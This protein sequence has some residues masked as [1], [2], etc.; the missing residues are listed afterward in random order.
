[1]ADTAVKGP[2]AFTASNGTTLE[3][4]DSDFS[5]INGSTGYTGITGNK[6]TF[7]FS[8]NST[9]FLYRD[10][11]GAYTADQYASAV[12]AFPGGAAA[13][14]MLACRV[15]ADTGAGRDA[16]L[17][18]YSDGSGV[19]TVERWDNGTKTTLDTRSPSWSSGDSIKLRAVTNG[20]NC[21]LIVVRNGAVSYTIS[22][23]S[24][25]SSGKPGLAMRM[26]S[27]GIVTMDDLELGNVTASGGSIA[28]ISNYYS[29]MRS[30]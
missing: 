18:R 30:A 21:D 27:G 20:A 16:Y 5:L 29:M 22:D 6:L 19:V 17:L 24:P 7:L 10:G 4:Y 8:D 2:L 1:M 25:L 28:A 26:S 12:L 11:V 23:T 15:S 13:E 3:A 14:M 9:D